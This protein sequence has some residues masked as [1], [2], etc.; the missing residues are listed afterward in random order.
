MHLVPVVVVAVEVAVVVNLDAIERGTERGTG[1][2]I[3]MI[4]VFLLQGET[5]PLHLGVEEVEGVEGVVEVIGVHDRGPVRGAPEEETV[6]IEYLPSFIHVS[7]YLRLLSM[8]VR[9]TENILTSEQQ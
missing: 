5:S 3:G 2:S 6:T 1:T 9:K 7:S 8:T 4:L